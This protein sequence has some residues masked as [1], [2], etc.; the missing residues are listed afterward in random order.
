MIQRKIFAASFRC[1]SGIQHRR[2]LHDLAL[3][4]DTLTNSVQS[5]HAL[6]GL[7]W[8]A[9]IPLTTFS[10]RA[11]ITLPL[12]VVQR[13]RIQKQSSLRPIVSAT[14][15]VLKLNLAKKVQKAQQEIEQND[16]TTNPAL[17]LLKGSLSNMK[18]EE[19]LLLAAK[20]TRKRQKTLFKRHGVQIWKNITLPAIQIPLWVGMS[21][22]MR[23]LSGWSTWDV[24]KNQALDPTLYSEGIL[25]FTDLTCADPMH[26][27]PLML[28]VISL[29]NV[30]WTFKTIKLL[31]PSRRRAFRSSLTDAMANV[32]RMAVVF[33]MAISL[34]APVSLV[35]YWFSSQ[36]F[37]LLQNIVMDITLPISFTPNKRFNYKTSE[38]KTPIVN[39]IYPE[40]TSIM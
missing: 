20:E 7:P 8:W 9:F 13:K 30:E 24:M 22:A 5:L 11:V 33:M 23:N 25:W 6:S 40:K 12:A 36:L 21:V 10:L 32:S 37:S 38:N 14:N 16:N 35:L 31:L 19:I 29:C 1:R 2:S 39:T 26:V 28:G 34:H 27:F 18:Y 15:P 3:T 17:L 4:V